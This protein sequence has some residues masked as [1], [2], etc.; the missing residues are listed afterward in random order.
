MEPE[1]AMIPDGDMGGGGGDDLAPD[2]EAAESTMPR[3]SKRASAQQIRWAQRSDLHSCIVKLTVQSVSPDYTEP[4]RTRAQTSRAGTGFLIEGQRIVT[5][6]HVV[7]RS[8]HVRARKSSSPVMYSCTVEWICVP[9]DLAVLSVNEEGRQA[10]FESGN[11]KS[12]GKAYLELRPI[13]P[14]LDENVTCVGFPT[15]GAQISVTRGVVSR[16]DVSG[17]GTLRIQIDA[18]INPVSRK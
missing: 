13:L 17:T 8:S 10:F 15:G 1:D 4:W 6:A 7:H 3:A 11:A 18:A 9:L 2:E 12:N 5:N 14:R 16:V